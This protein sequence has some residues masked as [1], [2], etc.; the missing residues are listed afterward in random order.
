MQDSQIPRA[1]LA[2]LSRAQATGDLSAAKLTQI[3]LDRI[4][5]HDGPHRSVIVT[6]P[7]A[8][9]IARALDDERANSGPRGPLHGMP[10]LVKDNLDTGDRM[11][12]TAGSLALADTFAP[13]DSTVAAKL[14][15]AG[16]IILGKANLSE[17]A[18]FRSTRSST[19]WSGVGGQCGNAFDPARSPGG[20]SSGSGV[21]VALGFCAAAIGT[22]TNGS[23]VLPSALNS[24]A[25]I[26][27]TLGLVSR[28]GIIPISASQDTAGPM[29]RTVEDAALVLDA[30]AGPDDADPATTAFNAPAGL[31]APG[32]SADALDGARLG[33][34][35][36]YTGYHD[37]LDRRF[38]EARAHL[39]AAG[40]IIIDGL[41]MAGT[42]E[43]R[44]HEAIVL[45][46][47]FKA[48]IEAYLATRRFENGPHTVA[49][50]IE[51]NRNNAERSMPH[52]G[53]ERLEAAAER[54]GLDDPEYL[55]ARATC[56]RLTRDDGIDRLLN[57]HQLDALIA[58]TTTP[59]WLTDWIMGDNRKGGA[60]A[61]AAVAGYPHV[62]V[63][64]GAVGHLPVG[65]SIFA[66]GGQDRR[67]IEL[68]H[69]FEQRTRLRQI[70]ELD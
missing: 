66:S 35:E 25:G 8:M 58:P 67:V 20:S 68:A 64:M 41:E 11:P 2:A 33:V 54:G 18:N 42:D 36:T 24:L 53:Q 16:A 40:A 44:Q 62:T 34:L 46:T 21:A 65:L 50:L 56:L 37:R 48:G 14:R 52:F 43:I 12:T 63:P 61:P 32:L 6:N 17:W 22:E 7:D 1:G 51:F 27:P 29:A 4:A 49:D 31:F 59:A 45:N 60:S 39:A 13:E 28:K 5:R 10:V 57:D 30:I 26:K 23:V 19:G 47:E 3:Y 38:E 9:D 69:A 55:E 15:D 70:P